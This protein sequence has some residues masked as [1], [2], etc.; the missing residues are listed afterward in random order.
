MNG[1]KGRMKMMYADDVMMC[2]LSHRTEAMI[3]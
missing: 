1:K 3:R 2:R